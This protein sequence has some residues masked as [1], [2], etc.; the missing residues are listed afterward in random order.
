MTG[1]ET[2]FF[3]LIITGL[4]QW[5][6]ISK[7]NRGPGVLLT[8][9]SAVFRSVSANVLR[10][11]VSNSFLRSPVSFHRRGKKIFIGKARL[12]VSIPAD[13]ENQYPTSHTHTRID[14]VYLNVVLLQPIQSECLSYTYNIY[15]KLILAI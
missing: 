9:D 14:P 11:S 3:I 13:S 1:W 2:K 4:M 8:T 15:F 7:T 5:S 12:L 6:Y 10:K